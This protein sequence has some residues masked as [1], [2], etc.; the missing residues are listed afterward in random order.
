MLMKMK[1]IAIE[2]KFDLIRW[3]MFLDMFTINAYFRFMMS[4]AEGS[5]FQ[6]EQDEELRI[7]V[8]CPKNEVVTVEL[9]TGM[10]EIFGTEMV[11]NNQ[12]R[13]HTGA[14]IAIFTFQGC[15]I[16]VMFKFRLKIMV[17]ST[18]VR[19]S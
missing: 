11:P 9:R 8:D 6:L 1:L 12:Y 16:V 3:R 15:T 18:K 2:I 4:S 14:K 19:Y 13:F 17:H 7:E 5:I 10:A